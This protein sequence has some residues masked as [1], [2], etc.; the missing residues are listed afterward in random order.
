MRPHESRHNEGSGR[1]PLAGRCSDLT[2]SRVIGLPVAVSNLA[3]MTGTI[4]AMAER[5][6]AGR[7]CVAN[8]HMLVTA[9]RDPAFP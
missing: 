9:R 2:W 4:A 3:A 6:E 7:V 1:S 5:G 8:V